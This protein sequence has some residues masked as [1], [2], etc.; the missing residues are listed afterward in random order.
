MWS[1][2][3]QAHDGGRPRATLAVVGTEQLGGR[4]DAR[5]ERPNCRNKGYARL[6]HLFGQFLGELRA[7]IVQRE[8]VVPRNLLR[9][10]HGPLPEAAHNRR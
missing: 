5:D 2:T 3:A 1:S 4:G 9:S 10:R 6:E 7:L 8:L